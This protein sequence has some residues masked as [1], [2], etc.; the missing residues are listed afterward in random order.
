MNPFTDRGHYSKYTAIQKAIFLVF[1]AL[2]HINHSSGP[3]HPSYTL[4]YITSIL[5]DSCR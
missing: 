2:L 5:G 1:E 3:T 4:T